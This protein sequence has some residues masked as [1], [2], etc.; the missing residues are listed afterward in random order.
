MRRSIIIFCVFTALSIFVVKSLCALAS[1]PLTIQRVELYFDN[2]RPEITVDKNYQKLKAFAKI[3][4]ENSGLLEGHWEVDGRILSQVSEHLTTG[5]IVILE[6]PDIPPLPT[7]DPGTHV[8]RL[9]IT[10]P[11]GI[12]F[13]MPSMFYFVTGKDVGEATVALKLLTP[14]ENSSLAYKTLTFTWEKLTPKATYIIQFYK[15]P[16]AASLFSACTMGTSYVLPEVVLRELF[17]PGGKY[18]WSVKG[19]D[20]KTQGESMLRKFRFVTK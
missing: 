11:S 18:Y 6:T 16:A 17:M 14:K 9:V 7:F 5:N 13:P 3:T 8:G 20:G 19:N 1:P 10:D 15:D 12:T 2:N 4:F